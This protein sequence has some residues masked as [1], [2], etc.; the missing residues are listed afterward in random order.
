MAMKKWLCTALGA[1]M[2]AGCGFHLRGYGDSQ[3]FAFQRLYIA[4]PGPL[5]EVLRQQLALRKELKLQ[6]VGQGADAVLSIDQENSEK[7]L[8]TVN[9][10]GQ[11]TQYLVLYQARYTLRIGDEEVISPTSLQLRRTLSFNANAVLGKESEEQRLIADMRADMAQQIARRIAVVRP[12]AGRTDIPVLPV[13][14][15]GAPS[16][17]ESK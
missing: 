11:V 7:Q 3:P 6:N 8:F 12:S 4:S 1:M 2:L 17:Q 9:G 5:G 10:S 16:T 14:D 15:S 13:P